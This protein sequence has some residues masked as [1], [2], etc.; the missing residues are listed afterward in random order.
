MKCL[1][2]CMGWIP[3]H[4]ALSITMAMD[5]RVA[6]APRWGGRAVVREGEA[7]PESGEDGDLSEELVGVGVRRAKNKRAG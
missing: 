2:V 5:L 1:P 6:H 3:L 4:T 7:E